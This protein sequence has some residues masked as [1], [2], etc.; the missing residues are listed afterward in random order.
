MNIFILFCFIFD[1]SLF[2]CVCRKVERKEVRIQWENII[3]KTAYC[4]N[5]HL[6]TSRNTINCCIMERYFALLNLLWKIQLCL[7]CTR[8]QHKIIVLRRIGYVIRITIISDELLTLLQNMQLGRLNN[9]EDCW[10]YVPRLFG[11]LGYVSS[12]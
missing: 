2:V 10:F 11:F 8:I 12:F 5:I 1:F 3:S 7:F 9:V 4:L 6:Y